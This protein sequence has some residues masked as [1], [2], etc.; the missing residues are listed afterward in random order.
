LL[1]NWTLRLPWVFQFIGSEVYNIIDKTFPLSLLLKEGYVWFRGRSL[2]L[3]GITGSQL[4]PLLDRSG[5]K[6]DAA[7][8][9]RLLLSQHQP[10]K[11]TSK[12]GLFDRGVLLIPYES[13]LRSMC[14]SEKAFE[15]RASVERSESF[16][17]GKRFAVPTL[18]ASLS[19]R[20]KI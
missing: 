7:F 13:I 16:A 8:G 5:G 14:P 11:D 1:K 2:L 6:A 15:V 19:P 10:Q 4:R 12:E 3:H 17:L 9:L 20:A 18:T